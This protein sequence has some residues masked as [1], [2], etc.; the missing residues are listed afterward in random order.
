ML[1]VNHAISKGPWTKPLNW[2]LQATSDGEPCIP[3]AV[4]VQP[5]LTRLPSPFFPQFRTLPT[6]LQL[7]I[8]R[9]CDSPALFRLMQVS[10]AM[11]VEAKK[12]FWS[13]PDAW[14]MVKADWLLAGGFPGHAH[15]A[16]D[17]LPHI[18]QI[19]VSFDHM[20]SLRQNW[21]AEIPRDPVEESVVLLQNV[22]DRVRAF[23]QTLQYRFPC[24]TSVV[25]SESAP[26]KATESLPVDLKMMVEMCPEGIRASASFLKSVADHGYLL[27]RSLWRRDVRATGEWQQVASSWMRH[28]ILLPPKDFRGP[29]GAYDCTYYKLHRYCRQKT[30]AKLLVI[31]AVERHHF[32]ERRKP[33]NC[34][35]PGCGS[36][37]EEPGEWTLHALDNAH[38]PCTVVPEE[39]KPLFDRHNSLLEHTY[40]QDRSWDKIKAD[41]GEEGSKERHNAEQAFLYQLDHD[42][43]YA[44]G[45]SAREC[46]KWFTYKLNLDLTYVYG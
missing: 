10:S 35:E 31:E 43:L 13:Y 16:I 14:Y 33:F 20:Y 4:Y 28:N 42:P 32:H 15:H 36:R 40:R 29:V 5:E 27:E 37:F 11:R 30:A 21:E 25:V 38:Y 7:R 8:L 12:L 24:A 39:V 26:R 22:E 2:N 6:E 23:W 17:I 34:F 3:F 9:F 19:E 45:K 18:E 44:H 46:S 1:R 41:W